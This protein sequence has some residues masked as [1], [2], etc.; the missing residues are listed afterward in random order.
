MQNV[1]LTPKFVP[2]IGTIRRL[3]A[4]AIQGFPL[5]TTF[6]N[7]INEYCKGREGFVP[8]KRL[9]F[10][11]SPYIRTEYAEAVRVYYEKNC[12]TPGPLEYVRKRAKVLVQGPQRPGFEW[13]HPLAW[14]DIDMDDPQ[15]RPIGVRRY[16]KRRT[17]RG[18]R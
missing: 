13:A 10:P 1:P 14:D 8:K 15:A 6:T 2:R 12:M 4:L 7:A 16:T 11:Y 18:R 3:Q 5:R 9:P 17:P